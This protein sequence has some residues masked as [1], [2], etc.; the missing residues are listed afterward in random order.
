MERPVPPVDP[1]PRASEEFFK[2]YE[3]YSKTLRTWLVAYGIGVPV[4]LL[5]NAALFTAFAN[6]PSA[7]T[8]GALFLI[9][10]ALQVLLALVNKTAMWGCFYKARFPAKA[11]GKRFRLAD[12]V[13]EQF[14]IDFIVDFVTL[15]VFSVATWKSFRIIIP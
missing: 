8:T 7:A 1:D 11:T 13:S 2:V 5:N 14:W 4:L 9:G 3:E 12:W 15:I 10:V 6:A